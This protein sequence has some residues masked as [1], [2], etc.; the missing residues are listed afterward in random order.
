VR[1]RLLF[2]DDSG[3]P[4]PPHPSQV[5]AI[6]GFAIDSDLYPDFSR[7]VLGA[8]DASSRTAEFP[9]PGS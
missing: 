7:R 3:K 9:R 4:D 5:V 1:T 6:A 8:K 2:L